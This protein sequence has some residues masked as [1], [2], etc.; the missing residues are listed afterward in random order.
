MGQHA[1]SPFLVLELVEGRAWR[2]GWPARPQPAAWAAELVETLARAIHAAHQQGV[3]HR[4]LTPANI[5]LTADG[6]PKITDFGLAKLL[7]G[8]GDLRTQTGELLGTPSYMAPEQAAGRHAAIGAATDVYALG[9]ILYELLTGRPP[10]KARV[11]AGDAAPGGRRRAGRAVAA[12]A[13]AAPRPGDDLPEVPAEGAG[14]AVC[15]RPG[16]GRGPAAVPRGPADPGAAEP[17]GRAGLAVVPPQPRGWPAA[18]TAAAAVVILAIVVDR[19][20]LDVPR[21]AR[22]DR[23][24][25]ALMSLSEARERRAGS[26]PR[27]SSSRRCWTGAAPGGAAVS[28]GQR[29]D[30]LAALEQAAAIARELKLPPERLD[31]LRDEAIACLALPDLRPDRR[32]SSHS[33]PGSSCSPSTPTM[34]R[35]A[36][37]VPG[38]DDGPPRRRRRGGRPLPGPGR[39][40][41]RLRLQPRRPIP[42]DGAFPGFA[43]TVWDIDRRVAV[44]SDPGPI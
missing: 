18:S 42:G 4:D 5:L 21:P 11:A 26:K 29:F 37:A 12:A 17:L 25:L 22:P 6:V 10:F 16:P 24:D 44:V 36:L 2:S 9:A 32:G 41:A 23:Q 40:R 19:G 14:A 20:G 34:T 7:V 27:D 28:V 30:S 35:Y 33:R 39:S 43:L 8:G 15:Q 3:V 1:G 13:Q 38:R 31:A